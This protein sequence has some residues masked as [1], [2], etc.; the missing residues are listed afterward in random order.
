MNEAHNLPA[1]VRGVLPYVAAA[2]YKQ[3]HPIAKAILQSASAHQ[4]TLPK[5][6]EANGN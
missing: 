1:R 3:T 2:E 4:L 5:I 6:D